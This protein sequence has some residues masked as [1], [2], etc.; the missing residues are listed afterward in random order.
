[1]EAAT[2]TT[3]L[4]LQQNELLK[5]KKMKTKCQLTLFMTTYHKIILHILLKLSPWIE[6]V[7]HALKMARH[8]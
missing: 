6:S 8:L 7:E 4:D 3:L 1:M 2:Q 5:A